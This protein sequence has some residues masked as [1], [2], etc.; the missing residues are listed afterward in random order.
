MKLGKIE[1]DLVCF[2]GLT[3]WVVKQ[4][5]IIIYDSMLVEIIMKLNGGIKRLED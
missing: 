1:H 3:G 2:L 4:T 5:Q